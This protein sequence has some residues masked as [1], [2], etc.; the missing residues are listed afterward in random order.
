M[1]KSYARLVISRPF[2]GNVSKKVPWHR[3][4][5]PNTEKIIFRRIFWRRYIFLR[6]NGLNLSCPE[7]WQYNSSRVMIA[8]KFGK[9]LTDTRI[10]M[11]FFRKICSILCDRLMIIVWIWRLWK[12]FGGCIGQNIITKNFK[13]LS[14]R[15]FER[16][17]YD[18][19]A[20]GSF[21]GK[22]KNKKSLAEKLFFVYKMVQS[23][24]LEPVTS[25]F[26]GRRSNPTEL[27]LQVQRV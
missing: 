2:G 7:F 4:V 21:F 20:R 11:K 18:S 15:I 10:I 13:I 12:S 26:A 27:R 16:R 1:I 9:N 22:L 8:M 14:N 24:G 5:H 23:T 17:K 3:L 25:S 19:H 6:M